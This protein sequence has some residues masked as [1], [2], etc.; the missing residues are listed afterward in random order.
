MFRLIFSLCLF[1]LFASPV[2]AAQ[3]Y[4]KRNLKIPAKAQR[5]LSLSPATTEMLF[6]IG[7]EKKLIG[8]THDCNYP[9]AATK[10]IRVGRFGQIQL[11]AII[12]L[13]P[14][15][16][17]V[18]ADMG[19]ALQALKRINTPVLAF[20]TPNLQAIEQNLN[21]LGQLTSQQT[22]A[23]QAVAQFHQ[24]LQAL[25]KDKIK[26]TRVIYLV[27]DQPLIVA[28]PHSFIGNALHLSGAQ[29]VVN[30]GQAPFVHY[31]LE[32]LLKANPQV[33]IV[34]KSIRSKL[35]LN[36]AP[37]NRLQAVKANRILTIEDDLIS[38]PGPRVIQAV[39]QI[40]RYLKGLKL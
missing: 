40:H 33:L 20:Q 10:K 26:T 12:K 1:V 14:D 22:Q 31:S 6:A 39:E 15:L 3:D 18:T 21:Q 25:Q 9:A 32:S 19:Q 30:A 29:N 36:Q 24:R 38:R 35:K 4:F 23:K 5:I 16:I 17:L 8:V 7:A 11:E 28:N 13:K 2:S 27:W 37:Y 34:P